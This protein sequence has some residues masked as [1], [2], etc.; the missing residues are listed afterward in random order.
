MKNNRSTIKSQQRF[1]SNKHNVFTEDVIK[2]SL[3]D[4][5][6][7]RIQSIDPVETYAYR[8]RKDL[9]FFFLNDIK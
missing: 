5:D 4:N 6:N 1:G 3:T 7:K 2:T 9:V 8:M